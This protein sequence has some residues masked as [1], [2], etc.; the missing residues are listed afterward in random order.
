MKRLL[1]L[2]KLPSRKSNSGQSLVEF[3]LLLPV[4]I[5]FIFGA[6]DFGRAFTAY[7]AIN[8]AAREAAHYG[9]QSLDNAVESEMNAI[10]VAEAGDPWGQPASA[11]S[12]V[13]SVL[14]GCSDSYGYSYVVVTV[15]Y[16]FDPIMDIVPGLET[17]DMSRTVRMRVIN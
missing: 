13:C 3:A 4:L 7:I 6:M 12:S 17:V 2:A 14:E 8:S 1:S 15:D 5:L 11:S 9:S 10:A 16:T